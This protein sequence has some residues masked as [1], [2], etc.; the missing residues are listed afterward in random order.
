MSTIQDD[1]RVK[2]E[3]KLEVSLDSEVT[4]G[5]KLPQ[6]KLPASEHKSGYE[7]VRESYV[8]YL[9]GDYGF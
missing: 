5:H 7:L 8:F 6:Q 4:G 1:L 3:V 2:P 9:G